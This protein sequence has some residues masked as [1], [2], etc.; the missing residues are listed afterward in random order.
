MGRMWCDNPEDHRREA[1]LDFERRGRADTDYRHD[2]HYDACADEYMKE[3]RRM[4][5]EDERRRE[6]EEEERRAEQ[7]RH[8]A[9]LERQCQE[10]Y[11]YQEEIDRMEYERQQIDEQSQEEV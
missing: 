9:Y 8:E 11:A 4:E 3:F 10:E 7:R 2:E 6:E 5:R 1:R